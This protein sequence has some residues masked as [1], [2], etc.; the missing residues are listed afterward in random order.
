MFFL[1]ILDNATP[2]CSIFIPFARFRLPKNYKSYKF[3]KNPKIF[4]NFSKFFL[5]VIEIFPIFAP[6]IKT[7][8]K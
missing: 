3:G 8:G 7:K 5:E 2:S 1:K 6:E 4:C